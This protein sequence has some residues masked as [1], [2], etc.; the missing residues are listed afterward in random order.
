MSVEVRRSRGSYFEVEVP[1]D[2]ERGRRPADI[3]FIPVPHSAA[4]EDV[5]RLLLEIGNVLLTLAVLFPPGEGRLTEADRRYNAYFDKL[6]GIAVAGI[7]QD[8]TLVGLRTLKHLQEEIIVREG[9]RIKNMHIRRLGLAA[10]VFSVPVLAIYLALICGDL[11]GLDNC[12]TV[13]TGL[14]EFRAFLPLLIGAAIGCWLSYALRN[15][16]FEFAD[17][18]VIENDRLDPMARLLLVAAMTVVIGLILVKEIVV[19]EVGAFNT[20]FLTSGSSAFLIGLFCGLVEMGMSTVVRARANAFVG[21]VAAPPAG[22]VP[23][24]PTSPTP[25]KDDAPPHIPA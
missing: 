1:P 18:T 3:D 9:G 19:V 2:D 15:P 11:G 16:E 20:R 10:A 13:W 23:P 14:S 24:P 12:P 4:P 5:T 8:Q 17:L 7:G 6:A 21:L 22:S 25:P